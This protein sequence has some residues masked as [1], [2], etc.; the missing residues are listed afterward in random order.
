MPSP[1]PS[2]WDSLSGGLAFP[3]F[4]GERPPLPGVCRLFQSRVGRPGCPGRPSQ[5]AQLGL[6]PIRLP[7]V[8]CALLAVLVLGGGGG[9][10]WRGDP[11]RWGLSA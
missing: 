3:S 11:W 2:C 5:Q 6:L 7:A 10:A 9:D 4:K 1:C 8:V